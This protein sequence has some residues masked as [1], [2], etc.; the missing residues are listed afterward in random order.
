M[1]IEGLETEEKSA[2]ITGIKPGQLYFGKRN[3]NWKLLECKE[4]K[5]GCIYPTTLDYAFYSYEC[6]VIKT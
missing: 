5:N 1:I 2:D 4:L 6:F 3:T